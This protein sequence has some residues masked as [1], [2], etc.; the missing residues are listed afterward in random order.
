M[1]SAMNL[2][3]ATKALAEEACYFLQKPISKDDLNYVWQ[4]VYRSN[5]NIAKL[6]YDAVIYNKIVVLTI[7]L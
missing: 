5:I 7:N 2:K 3:V 1:S 6:T 4:H